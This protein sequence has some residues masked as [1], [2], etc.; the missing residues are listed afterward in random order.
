MTLHCTGTT[1]MLRR[2]TQPTVRFESGIDRQTGNHPLFLWVEKPSCFLWFQ[3]PTRV[4]APMELEFCS[5]WR[6]HASSAL[7]HRDCLG[8][9]RIGAQIGPLVLHPDTGEQN[10]Q[11]RGLLSRNIAGF[12]REYKAMSNA[13][14]SFLVSTL[15]V[16]TLGFYF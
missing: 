11:P 8:F 9:D 4:I 6:M 7:K 16:V 5:S 2:S 15:P 1:R 12:R 14:V 3:I 13:H 10:E